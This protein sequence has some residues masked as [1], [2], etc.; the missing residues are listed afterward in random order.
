MLHALSTRKRLLASTLLCGV[1]APAVVASPAF[2]Q[3]GPSAVEEIVVTGS[4]IA[5]RAS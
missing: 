5:H 2:A 1:I 4:R 3:E